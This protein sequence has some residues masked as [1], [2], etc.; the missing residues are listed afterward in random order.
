MFHSFACGYFEQGFRGY[1]CLP[2]N[3]WKAIVTL[4][5]HFRT[6]MSR[7]G[8]KCQGDFHSVHKS[9]LPFLFEAF[10]YISYRL[11]KNNLGGIER[12]RIKKN[13]IKAILIPS[14]LIQATVRIE[15]NCES[16]IID[17]QKNIE[18]FASIVGWSP[19]IGVRA[20]R[21]RVEKHRRL[22]VNDK[23]NCCVGLPRDEA[24]SDVDI[25]PSAG[26]IKLL[27]D[28]TDLVIEVEYDTFVYVPDDDNKGG[29][30]NC[31]Y[32]V[33]NNF[34]TFSNT[35]PVVYLPNNGLF[36]YPTNIKLG[37]KFMVDGTLHRITLIQSDHERI[38]CC[39]RNQPRRVVFLDS[40]LVSALIR[41]HYFG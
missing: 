6:I 22:L 25:S 37:R 35:E 36:E 18:G 4:Q 39:I 24:A 17:T 10:M 27:L 23:V 12:T 40:Q 31:E 16:I 33:I 19:L 3:I 20:R 14:G 41:V 2:Q 5:K 11:K 28:D 26:V 34:I 21:P 9:K 13:T 30:K 38:E 8:A 15:E 1:S 29:T 7:Y 32:D